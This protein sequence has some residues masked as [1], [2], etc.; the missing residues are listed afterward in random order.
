MLR[1]ME[2]IP[3]II[4]RV[5][6]GKPLTQVQKESNHVKSKIRC[7]VEHVFGCVTN[8]M[9]DFYTFH[10]FCASYGYNR[11]KTWYT[12]FA[13]TNN[14]VQGECKPILFEFA[15]PQPIFTMVNC[16]IKSFSGK[17]LTG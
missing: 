17:I 11:A 3:Q 10:R 15:E 7:L 16:E 4:E 6:K 9:D 1:G 13:V 5:F 8:S 12:I 14:I 2:I